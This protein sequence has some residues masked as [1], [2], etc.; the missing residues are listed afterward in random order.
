VLFVLS[1]DGYLGSAW[2]GYPVDFFGLTLLSRATATAGVE[3]A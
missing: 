3:G 2:S 1:I